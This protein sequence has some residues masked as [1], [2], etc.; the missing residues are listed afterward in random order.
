M[1][2]NVGPVRAGLSFC[3]RCRVGGSGQSLVEFGL[4]AALIALVAVGTVAAVGTSVDGVL[5]VPAAA[6]I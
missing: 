6:G 4:L 3:D 5:W 2:W 1:T